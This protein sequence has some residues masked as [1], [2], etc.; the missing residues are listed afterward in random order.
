MP[1]RRARKGET[2]CRCGAYSFPHREF[3]GRCSLEGYVE[4]IWENNYGGGDCRNC[5]CFDR[6]RMECQIV[7]G[8]ENALKCPSLDEYI[9]FNDIRLNKTLLEFNGRKRRR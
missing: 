7:T 4:G 3:G 1:K 6:E 2:V 8:L 9:R 5:H